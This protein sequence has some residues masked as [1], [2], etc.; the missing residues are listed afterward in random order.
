MIK[1]VLL[2]CIAVVFIIAACT[3]NPK[4]SSEQ[5]NDSSSVISATPDTTHSKSDK[6]QPDGALITAVFEGIL[7]C[8]DCP[9]LQTKLVIGN[10][11]TYTLEEIYL[12]RNNGKAFKSKGFLHIERDF[13]GE[14]GTDLFVLTDSKSG[15]VRYF[16][17]SKDNDSELE[18]LDGNKQP[19]NSTNNKLRK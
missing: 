19:I 3:N 9:G 13:H 18:I 12:E 8:A 16:R 11:N 2:A 10:D 1:K 5:L 4:G 15:T 17:Q 6:P 14:K 7:P